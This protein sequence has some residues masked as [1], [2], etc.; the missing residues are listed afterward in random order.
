MKVISKLSS[1]RFLKS[2]KKKGETNPNVNLLTH[3]R[4]V[5]SLTSNSLY[6][7]YS[8]RVIANNFWVAY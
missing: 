7:Q 4:A 1:M 8:K 3:F 6:I 2:V 5:R